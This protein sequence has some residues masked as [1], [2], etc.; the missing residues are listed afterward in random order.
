VSILVMRFT[1]SGA[2]RRFFYVVFISVTPL[3]A[4]LAEGGSNGLAS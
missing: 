1:A 2:C 4:L 3:P